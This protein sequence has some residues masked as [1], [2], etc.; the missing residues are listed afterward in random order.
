MMRHA[1]LFGH[2]SYIFTGALTFKNKD[3]RE[4][5][6]NQ[7]RDLV[8]LFHAEAVPQKI[9]AVELPFALT[10]PDVLKGGDLQVKLVGVMDLV[11]SDQD[12]VYCVVEL[13][14]S[15]QRYSNIKLE[16]DLQATIYSY[17]MHRMRLSTSEN[18]T[19]VRYDVLV[20]NKKPLFER[21]FVTRTNADHDRMIHLIN[22]VLRAIEQRIFYR[23]TGWQCGDCQFRK[24]CLS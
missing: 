16:H 14:T 15:S 20:K 10:I 12:G 5:L 18:S 3:D 19:L 7:G 24:T 11:E 22:Q 9:V 13:K 21:Y 4:T 17:A 8:S 6:R 1:F 23:Q 2:F